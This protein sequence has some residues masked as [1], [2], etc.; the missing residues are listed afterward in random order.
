MQSTL[1]LSL[2]RKMVR[3]VVN[4]PFFPCNVY[5]TLSQ[6]LVV[7]YS[8]ID[9]VRLLSSLCIILILEMYSKYFDPLNN[10]KIKAS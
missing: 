4:V 3:L 10:N 7:N 6:L 8:V 1:A 9:Y 5:R 2:A